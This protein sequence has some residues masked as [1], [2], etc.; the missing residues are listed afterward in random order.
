[1][2]TSN[3]FFYSIAG[4]GGAVNVRLFGAALDIINS[5]LALLIFF[6]ELF[7]LFFL[8]KT[9]TR[10]LSR[11]VSIEILSLLFLPGI[12]IHELSHLLI[13]GILFVPVG[14]IEFLPKVSEGGVKL[15]SVAIGKTD[16]IRRAII[17]VAPVLV[18]VLLLFGVGSYFIHNGSMVQT[19][20]LPTLGKLLLVL[21][22]IF[23]IA[24]TMFSSAKD[25]EGFLE[26]MVF[27]G[28]FA[29]VFYVFTTISGLSLPSFSI[30]YLDRL[31]LLF[32]PL[33]LVLGI[34]VL[35]DS[36]VIA[37]LKFFRRLS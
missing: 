36:L 35:I 24:N 1:M 23:A 32:K 2:L 33:V 11:L 16:P 13:A 8:S 5:M 21:Y 6:T 14:E 31:D 22:G 9:L 20:E 29:L 4:T 7:F 18:G 17:G 27:L 28:F 15:G 25:L 19:I 26:V 10:L 3:P 34:S 12:I 37:A 30:P